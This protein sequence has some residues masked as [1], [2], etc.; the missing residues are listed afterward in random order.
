MRPDA[1]KKAASRRYQAKQRG[2]GTPVPTKLAPRP[3]SGQDNT[4]TGGRG[5]FGGG[6]GGRYR[7]PVVSN[8]W[9]FD[10]DGWYHRWNEL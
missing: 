10:H 3:S 6:D 1:H 2:N 7:R 4:S 5:G 9:R 8:A